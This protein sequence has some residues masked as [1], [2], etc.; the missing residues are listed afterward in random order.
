LDDESDAMPTAC[1]DV[2]SGFF[3][4]TYLVPQCWIPEGAVLLLN[5]KTASSASVVFC[6][7]EGTTGILAAEYELFE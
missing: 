5:G 4:T 1:K 6:M 3:T 2:F 7:S